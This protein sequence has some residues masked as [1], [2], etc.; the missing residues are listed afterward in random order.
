VTS[1]I[2]MLSSRSDVQAD[3]LRTPGT[4]FVMK[5]SDTIENIY[6]VKVLNKTFNRMAVELKLENVPGHIANIGG[7]YL[8]APGEDY[9]EGIIAITIPKTNLQKT[10]N[11][12]RIGVYY[13]GKRLSIVKTTFMAP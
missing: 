6:N 8:V 12:I 13:K 10:D 4:D 7:G 9:G 11:P 5:G 1:L 2:I 3:I